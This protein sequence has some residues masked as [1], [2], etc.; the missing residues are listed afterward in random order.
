MRVPGEVLLTQSR[1]GPIF[2]GQA[3]AIEVA[4]LQRDPETHEQLNVNTDT[5]TSI[6]SLLATAAAIWVSVTRCWFAASLLVK[7]TRTGSQAKLKSAPPGKSPTWSCPSTRNHTG[8]HHG[9]D[10][11][12]LNNNTDSQLTG[13]AVRCSQ[14]CRPNACRCARHSAATSLPPHGRIRVE[15]ESPQRPRRCAMVRARTTVPSQHACSNPRQ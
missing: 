6:A 8:D 7:S 2:G 15:Q 13:G 3:V 1:A 9:C 14:T 11:N 4:L 10:H 12:Y 5:G